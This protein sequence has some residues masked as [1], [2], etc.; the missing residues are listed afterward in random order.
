MILGQAAVPLKSPIRRTSRS[1][2]VIS[3]GRL[4][5]T[6]LCDHSNDGG[7]L[8]RCQLSAYNVKDSGISGDLFWAFG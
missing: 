8:L 6:K 7:G 1:G 3:A 5:G 4:G 2:V